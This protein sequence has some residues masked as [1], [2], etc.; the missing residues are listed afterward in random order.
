MWVC[1]RLRSVGVG[2][3][4]FNSLSFLGE[5]ANYSFKNFCFVFVDLS[6][7]EYLVIGRHFCSASSKHFIFQLRNAIQGQLDSQAA[8]KGKQSNMDE[9]EEEVAIDMEELEI[10]H[11]IPPTDEYRLHEVT[12]NGDNQNHKQG[13]TTTAVWKVDQLI[14]RARFLWLL[15]FGS[16]IMYPMLLI[17]WI[18]IST[19][20][21][22]LMSQ[23]QVQDWLHDVGVDN[24]DRVV[25]YC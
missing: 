4:V 3:C 20:L 13:P 24:K 14:S 8:N 7:W 15:V 19:F 11:N 12:S 25:H 5:N 18:R 1:E 21:L 10:V 6:W 9:E 23:T 16:Q 17:L 22:K 2:R